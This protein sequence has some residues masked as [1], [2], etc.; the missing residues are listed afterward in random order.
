[1]PKTGD[2][3]FN[4]NAQT[5][6][7]LFDKQRSRIAINLQNPRLKQIHLHTLRHW[8]ATMEFHRTLNIKV[9]QQMLDHKK[10]ETTDLYTQLIS[11]ESGEWN[12]A[13]ARNLEEESKLIEAGFEYVHYSEKDQVAIYRKRK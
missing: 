5:I 13:H 8:K 12:V 10:L 11:F 4:T 6:R 9:V 3:V 1:M 7:N 2:Y